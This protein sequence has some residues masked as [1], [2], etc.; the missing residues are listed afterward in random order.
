MTCYV[1]SARK[2]FCCLH[3]VLDLAV[4]SKTGTQ[5]LLKPHFTL[6][7]LPFIIPVGCSFVQLALC[8]PGTGNAQMK[9]AQ[10][11]PIG[12]HRP[13]PDCKYVA[14]LSLL[15]LPLPLAGPARP[16]RWHLSLLLCSAST[17]LLGTSHHL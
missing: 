11:F 9:A 5:G 10:P 8:G 7:A 6:P 4:V 13:V 12:A 16:P 14:Q 2:P 1:I 15:P 3:C 17:L